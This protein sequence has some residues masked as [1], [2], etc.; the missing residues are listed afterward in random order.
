MTKNLEAKI[1]YRSY[2]YLFFVVSSAL[3]SP[4]LPDTGGSQTSENTLLSS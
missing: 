4:L 1:Y 2:I 3:R